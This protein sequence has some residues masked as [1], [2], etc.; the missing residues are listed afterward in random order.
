MRATPTPDWPLVTEELPILGAIVQGLSSR[1]GC[2]PEAIVDALAE[3]IE[4]LEQEQR[5]PLLR[6]VDDGER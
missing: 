6:L 1:S 5:R 4:E 3:L 2:P